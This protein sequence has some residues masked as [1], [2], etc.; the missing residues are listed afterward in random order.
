MSVASI[1]S[2]VA[3]GARSA[4][5]QR[6]SLQTI[7]IL[8]LLIEGALFVLSAIAPSFYLKT[9]GLLTYS[10][11][12]FERQLKAAG[13][14]LVIYLIAARLFPVYSPA[15]VLDTKLNIKRLVLV[16]IATFSSLVAIAAATKTTE[17][18]SRLWFFGWT[19]SATELIIFARLCVLIQVKRKLQRGAYVFRA[20]SLGI[21]ALPL[22]EHELRLHTNNKMHTVRSST[23]ISADELI[24]LSELI[25]TEDIDQVFIS[26]PWSAIPTLTSQITNLR[27]LAVDIFLCCHDERLRGEILEV[28]HLG[29]GLAIQAGFRPLAGWASWVK[30]CEDI[31]F[32]F[33]ILAIASPVIAITALAIKLE[34]RGPILFQQ[35]RKGL[36]GKHF[37]LFKFRSMYMDHTDL[38]AE[39]QTSKH[40]PRVTRVGRLIRRLSID[41]LPQLLNVLEGSMSIVGPRPHALQT[42]AEGRRLEDIVDYYALRHRVKSGITGWA[43]VNGFRG[44]L[45]SIQKLEAR[46]HHDIYYLENWSLWL[47]LNIILRTAVQVIFDRK[48]Y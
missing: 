2:A 4:T 1:G 30:R 31:V 34:T 37:R 26:V 29:D 14:G 6:V 20:L 25:R 33:L 8:L 18:H 43:Q 17:I 7:V 11:V 5:E 22:S 15:H 39:R 27:S 23:V 16:C 48:A 19:V 13:F 21:G 35:T 42:S 47:D 41:E 38:H 32:S 40:D 3:G 9:L 46:V 12:E 28:Q 45:D 36:N 24:S 10:D 44:E